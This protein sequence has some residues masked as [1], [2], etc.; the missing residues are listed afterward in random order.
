MDV[1]TT[2]IILFLSFV[3]SGYSDKDMLMSALKMPFPTNSI[4]T[5]GPHLS[6]YQIIRLL[7]YGGDACVYL[8]E[9]LQSHMR[10]AIKVPRLKDSEKAQDKLLYEAR[11]LA[12]LKHP[13]IVPVYDF[14]VENG[15]PFLA[16][17]YAPYGTVSQCHAL[18]KPLQIS[19]ILCYLKQVAQALQ[20][21]HNDGFIHQDIKSENLLLQKP[22]HIW[23]CDFSIAVAVDALQN[24]SASRS[25]GTLPYMAPEQLRGAPCQA[26]DQYSL[27]IVVYEWLCGETP[28]QGSCLSIMKQHLSVTPP[29]L[30]KIVPALSP[31]VDKVMQKALA[32]DPR[33]RYRS[34][35]AFASALETALTCRGVA[36]LHPGYFTVVRKQ[37][38]PL[39]SLTT[40]PLI[41]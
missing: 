39:L 22:G 18:Q 34:V 1:H 33:K 38:L 11:I 31:R 30:S 37:Q 2:A 23:L 19:T 8:A 35:S 36:R 3:L 7:G 5:H 24:S 14:G 6:N 13:H 9:H 40:E 4:D 28:F 21:L 29:L 20:F 27:G 15:T 12:S 17:D 41:Y 16:M 26:S 25:A 32:K 10:V